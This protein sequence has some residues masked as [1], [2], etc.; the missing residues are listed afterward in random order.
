MRWIGIVVG[1]LLLLGLGFVLLASGALGRH[2]APGTPSET[3]KSSNS[4]TG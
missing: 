2:Q 3:P 1:I 4:W